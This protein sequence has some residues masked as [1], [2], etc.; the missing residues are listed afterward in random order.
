MCLE[1]WINNVGMNHKTHTCAYTNAHIKAYN[2]PINKPKRP[3][4][5]G[6]NNNI[7]F[8]VNY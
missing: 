5:T 4:K 3:T 7:C 2:Y 8:T 1:V 6:F